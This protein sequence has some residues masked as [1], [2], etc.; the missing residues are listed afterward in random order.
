M[1]NYV[2]LADG[3]IDAG[4]NHKYFLL[5]FKAAILFWFMAPEP[6]LKMYICCQADSVR[7]GNLKLL[8]R[9]MQSA[10]LHYVRLKQLWQNVLF[11][12]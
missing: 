4:D 8:P 2:H 3:E 6:P 12:N 5:L 7:R 9:L 11:R 10:G 1:G